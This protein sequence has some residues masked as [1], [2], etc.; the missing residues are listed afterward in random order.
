MW[1]PFRRYS[2]AE[3]YGL[4][5]SVLIYHGVPGRHRQLVRF[6]RQFIGP[7]DLCFDVG[8]HVGNRIRAW[9]ALGARVVAVEPQP[10]CLDFLQRW[11]GNNPAVTLV[12]Q[13]VGAQAGQTQLF[14]SA[15]TPT[16]TTMSTDWI[17]AVQA[18]DSF[19][20]VAWE[21]TVDIAVTTL[22]AL[23][24][25]YGLPDFCKIDI[26]GFEH[27]AL[28]GLNTPIPALSIE[29][30]PAAPIVT[31]ACLER[32]ATLGVYEFNW[33]VGERHIWHN[34]LWQDR[35]AVVNFIARLDP[36]RNSGD[37][38]ARLCRLE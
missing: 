31:L 2:L 19:A 4:L 3:Q 14:V 34:D 13:A 6:Y 17:Q 26:E 25:L 28:L 20:S 27:K 8:A 24:D 18:T 30:I 1:L 21:S 12:E 10:I 35:Q 36:N 37:I 7:G 32:L 11:Y 38:Y 33:T 15:K 29:Y 5:R 9:V 16:V 22:D 23:I